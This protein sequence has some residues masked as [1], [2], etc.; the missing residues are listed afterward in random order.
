MYFICHHHV[1]LLPPYSAFICL[2]LTSWST[3]LLLMSV[4]GSCCKTVIVWWGREAE[5]TT[6][7][8]VFLYTIILTCLNQRSWSQIQLFNM[9]WEEFH[10]PYLTLANCNLSCEEGFIFC[11]LPRSSYSHDK[12]IYQKGFLPTSRFLM[13]WGETLIYLLWCTLTYDICL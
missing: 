8:L 6:C 4:S 11:D 10:T 13:L 3:K 2:K 7:L 5:S 1:A 12:P 9:F